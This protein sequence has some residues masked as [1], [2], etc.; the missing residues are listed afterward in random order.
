MS[1]NREASTPKRDALSFRDERA[2]H[3]KVKFPRH[4]RYDAD[5]AGE[6]QSETPAFPFKN[7]FTRNPAIA[8][9]A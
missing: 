2:P 8:C 1:I 5:R 4:D 7:L 9:I 3:E 6:I